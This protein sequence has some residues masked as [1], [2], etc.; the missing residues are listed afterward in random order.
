[1]KNRVSGLA[2]FALVLIGLVAAQRGVVA[3]AQLPFT[4][5]LPCGTAPC[6]S[7]PGRYWI[8]LPSN[9]PI[10]TA[11]ELCATIPHALSVRQ[12]FPRNFLF[13]QSTSPREWLYDCASATCQPIGLTP[14]PSE[15]SCAIS[16]C[17]C[18]NPGAGFEV[19]ISAPSTFVIRGCESPVPIGLPP[20]GSYLVSVPYATNLTTW[21]SLAIAA[22]LRTTGFPQG[23]IVGRDRCT[24]LFTTLNAGST[25][26]STQ[27]LVAGDAYELRYFD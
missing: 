4:M 12:V 21:R 15:P 3:N 6:Q 27:P 26:A 23:Q 1:M 5:D 24:G 9:S 10:Q 18:V 8:S 25:Q 19:T 22:G 7:C 13:N 16:S 17:F 2:V 20:G 11:E 14:A